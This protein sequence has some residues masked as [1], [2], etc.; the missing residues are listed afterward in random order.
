MSCPEH[1]RRAKSPDQLDRALSGRSIEGCDPSLD[2]TGDAEVIAG[3]DK[4]G[5]AMVSPDL[6]HFRH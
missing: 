3:P 1:D 4:A 6:R 2:A 5:I